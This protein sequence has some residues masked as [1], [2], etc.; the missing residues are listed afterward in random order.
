MKTMK[1]NDNKN[2][3]KL[4]EKFKNSFGNVQEILVLQSS[5][6]ACSKKKVQKIEY[7]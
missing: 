1:T 7:I 3:S 6:L 4:K 5:L 2:I